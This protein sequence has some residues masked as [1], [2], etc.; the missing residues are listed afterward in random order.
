VPFESNAGEVSIWRILGGARQFAVRGAERKGF[1]GSASA[2]CCS[3]RSIY[4]Y[5]ESPSEYHLSSKLTR[6]PSSIK[7]YRFAALQIRI[8]TVPTKY[9]S[10]LPN[11]Q[12]ANIPQTPSTPVTRRPPIRIRRVLRRISTKTAPTPG[13]PRAADRPTPWRAVSLA[14]ENRILNGRH[15]PPAT[16]RS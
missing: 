5:P 16:S 13:L 4:C 10:V 8:L 7:Q 11:W 12:P 2:C 3:A 1:E 9:C 6:Q 15:R 14:S